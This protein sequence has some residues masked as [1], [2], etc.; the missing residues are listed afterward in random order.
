MGVFGYQ[1]EHN[2]WEMLAYGA[3]NSMTACKF[4]MP[5]SGIGPRAVSLTAYLLNYDTV[6]RKVFGAIYTHNAGTN[7][8]DRLVGVTE[9]I[10]VPVGKNWTTFNFVVQP[11]LCPN[12]IY[13]LVLQAEDCNEYD[14]VSI[15]YHTGASEQEVYTAREYA[16][17]PDP[18]VHGAYENFECCIYC[19]YVVPFMK[20]IHKRVT[21]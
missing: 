9:E 20:V 11:G 6:A 17:F 2:S 19:T 13:W 10:Q 15:C 16:A 1:G 3:G 8:P 4:T 21:G 5:D 12:T 14:G 7:K 18:W